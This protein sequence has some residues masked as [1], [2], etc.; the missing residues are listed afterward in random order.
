[1]SSYL[2][3]VGKYY[4]KI[5]SVSAFGIFTANVIH[6]GEKMP[7]MTNTSFD[8]QI[9]ASLFITTIGVK[10]L[11]YGLVW[12]LTSIGYGYRYKYDLFYEGLYVPFY[13]ISDKKSEKIKHTGQN[14][15][16]VWH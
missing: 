11:L 16:C 15:S 13:R 7:H 1:M 3:I 12:P 4:F 2:P 6:G 8:K 14:C 10:S 9:N 5:A